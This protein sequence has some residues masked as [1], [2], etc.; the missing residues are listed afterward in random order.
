MR[1]RFLD[2]RFR[3]RGAVHQ[4]ERWFPGVDSNP[5]AIHIGRDRGVDRDPSSQRLLPSLD[6][7][8]AILRGGN[9][10]LSCGLKIEVQTR[11]R[12]EMWVPVT[13]AGSRSSR[14]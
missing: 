9:Q 11:D 14:P 13:T 10:E 2:G 7:V 5:V 4:K 12:V 1:Q 3:Y 6:H 8:S